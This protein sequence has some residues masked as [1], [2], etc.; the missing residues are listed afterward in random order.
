MDFDDVVEE[1]NELHRKTKAKGKRMAI[2][3]CL[4][5]MADWRRDWEIRKAAI[6]AGVASR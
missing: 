4:Q 2:D 6:A 1:M 5:L 3:D